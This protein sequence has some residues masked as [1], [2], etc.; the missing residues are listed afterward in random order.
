M[1]PGC[2]ATAATGSDNMEMIAET[3]NPSSHHSND[4]L[5]RRPSRG[6]D[7]DSRT[8]SDYV[9]LKQYKIMHD[10]G[11]VRSDDFPARTRKLFREDWSSDERIFS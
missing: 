4:R 8:E 1:I 5:P 10:I 3:S 9:Q 7:V 6:D 11:K 2:R